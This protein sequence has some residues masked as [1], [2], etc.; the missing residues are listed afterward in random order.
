[1]TLTLRRHE[2]FI[3]NKEITV[4][5]VKITA[6]RQI[7]LPA[8]VLDALGLRAGDAIELREGPDGFILRARRID[9]A[10]LAPLRGKLRKSRG[11]FDLESLRD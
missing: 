6:K 1:M 10:R 8:R 3:E 5:I 11:T 9:R 7:T 2:F 4:M